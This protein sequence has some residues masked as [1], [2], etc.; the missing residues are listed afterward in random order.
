MSMTKKLAGG[1]CSLVSLPDLEQLGCRAVRGQW[2]EF[3]TSL[4]RTTPASQTPSSTR[5]SCGT[6]R[7]SLILMLYS[8]LVEYTYTSVHD[9]TRSHTRTYHV[10]T[11]AIPPPPSLEFPSM[12][13]PRRCLDPGCR[14]GAP[15]SLGAP[16]GQPPCPASSACRRWCPPTHS[17]I[18][19]RVVVARELRRACEARNAEIW[20]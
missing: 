17:G 12:F 7:G 8:R 10:Y 2:A 14:C 9:V 4:E 3:V 19:V 16:R 11:T 13:A 18:A 1:S 6:R 15:R 5:S 20:V